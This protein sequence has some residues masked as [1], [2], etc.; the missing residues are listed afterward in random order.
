MGSDMD[1]ERLRYLPL[2]AT[3]SSTVGGTLGGVRDLAQVVGFEALQLQERAAA[4][5]KEDG[6]LD[7][8]GFIVVNPYR[9]W[10]GRAV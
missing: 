6:C 9:R 10:P 2:P 5:A 8:D 3:T 7:A 4:C 1:H